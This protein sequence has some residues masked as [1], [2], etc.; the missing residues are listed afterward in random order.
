MKLTGPMLSFEAHGTLGGAITA[1][2]WRGRPFVKRKPDSAVRWTAEQRS[3]RARIGYLKKMWQFLPLLTGGDAQDQWAAV[4]DNVTSTPYH[5]WLATNMQRWSDTKAA[6]EFPGAVGGGISTPSIL[7]TNS[8]KGYITFLVASLD[9]A[10]EMGNMTYLRLGATPTGTLPFLVWVQHNEVIFGKRYRVT[11]THL[12]PGSYNMR[13]RI[14]RC[15]G[16][17]GSL[18]ATIAGIVVT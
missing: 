5:T 1:G 10:T 8:G 2:L 13:N 11:I 12:A 16:T 17:H 7:Q 14:W 6:V 15:D 9:G 4:T 3:Q 18:S